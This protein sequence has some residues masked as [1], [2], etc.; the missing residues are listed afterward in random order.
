MPTDGPKKR[1]M[2]GRWVHEH[3]TELYRFAYRACGD[4]D[5]AEDLVQETFY[6][7]WK[8][9][10]RLRHDDRARAWLYQILRHRY[11]RWRRAEGRGV[12][13]QLDAAMLASMPGPSGMEGHMERDALQYGL[14]H[15]SD[16]LKA[17]LLMVFMEGVTCQEAADR[18]DLPLG[19][20][21]SRIHRA[22]RRLREV[23][24]DDLARAGGEKRL[25]R[26]RFRI[27]GEP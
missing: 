27:G 4:R 8:S 5:V 11:A 9:I 10:G 14:D 23:L 16:R 19:T 17:P 13:R 3:A 6:E 24:H 2:Y 12:P 26:G 20:V 22:K 18:L 15:L 7:A 1:A 25:A 21:L